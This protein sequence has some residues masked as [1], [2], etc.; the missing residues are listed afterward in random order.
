MSNQKVLRLLENAQA[1]LTNSHFLYTSGKHGSAYVN[2]DAVY[3]FP[4]YM[5]ELG[6]EMAASVLNPEAVEVIVGPTMGGAIL[7]QWVAQ[8]LLEKG[9]NGF[10]LAF[11]EE[12]PDKSR[13][14]K[15]GYDQLIPGKKV[16][17]VEDILNTGISAKRTIDLIKSLGG[18]VVQLVAVCNRG[19]VTAETVGAPLTSLVDVKFEAWEAADCPL[20]KKGTPFNT[21]VGKAKK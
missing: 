6:Q 19:A 15:R 18:E 4:E 12:N 9:I 16:L 11:A 8:A 3:K 10:K 13:I 5:R 2:K 7:A 17:V 21:N 20:C 14:L 1:I